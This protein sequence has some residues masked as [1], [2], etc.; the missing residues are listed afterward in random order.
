MASTAQKQEKRKELRKQGFKQLEVWLPDN[1]VRR[2]DEMKN[3]IGVD[4]RNEVLLRLIE[5]GIGDDRL[6]AKRAKLEARAQ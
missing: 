4:S 2:I 5:G 6:P 3:T 1:V